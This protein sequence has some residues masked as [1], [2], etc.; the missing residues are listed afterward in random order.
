MATG[1]YE[2][3][4]DQW[5]REEDDRPRGIGSKVAA[6]PVDSPPVAVDRNLSG[7]DA[8]KRRLAMSSGIKPHTPP[9]SPAIQPSYDNEP[10]A[11][12]L[13]LPSAPPPS[14]PP[15]AET[16]DEAYLRRVAMSQ[17]RDAPQPSPVFP[18]P[19]SEPDSPPTLAYN[20]FAP[21]SVPPPPPGPPGSVPSAFEA[22]AK[23]AAAIAAKLG[24]LA[25]VGPSD[26][27]VPPVPAEEDISSKK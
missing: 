25:A 16:G 6:P 19:I 7:E 11:P 5:S 23:A 26:S 12:V 10:L 14:A 18:Q 21:P 13:S 8:F 17:R 24:A 22:R 3:H 9:Y 20:P 15:A 4:F 1:R 2:E 27:N